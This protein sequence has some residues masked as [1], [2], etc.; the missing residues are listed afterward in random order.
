MLPVA[1]LIGCCS[2]QPRPSDDW[3]RVNRL[4]G[5][6]RL[7]PAGESTGSIV[8]RSDGLDCRFN[9]GSRK[10]RFNGVLVWLN[11]G[12]RLQGEHVTVARPDADTVLA[13]L[14]R[15]A[16]VLRGF[17]PSTIVIDPGHGGADT[18]AIGPDGLHEKAVVLDVA[19][20]AARILERKGLHVRLTRT[21]DTTLPLA[22]R[23]R[24]ASQW[25]ADM[26]VSIHVNS[27]ARRGAAGIETY[28][29][30]PPDQPATAGGSRGPASPG[31][32]FD[33]ANMV[34]AY[35]V[36]G[37]LLSASRDEDRGIRRARFSVLKSAGCPAILTECGFLS[38]PQT[39][40]ALRR[41]EHIAALANAI[42]QGVLLYIDL[43][44]KAEAT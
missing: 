29:L 16:A 11:S 41:P 35:C 13:P 40:R 30:P 42:A 37:A 36:H 21:A 8:F 2:A 1:V 19:R 26:F 27:A 22:E 14:M 18:G 25:H 28:I 5:F 32:R 34:L 3:A 4:P 9:P 10:L 15:P 6:R 44:R 43:A 12:A 24:L 39:A 17:A 31:N 20:R 33:K 38:N 23:P 7:A